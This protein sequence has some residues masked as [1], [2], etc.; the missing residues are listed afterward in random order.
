MKYDVVIVGAGPGG[1]VAALS[2]QKMGLKTALVER[3]KIGSVL[4]RANTCMMVDTEGF[5]GEHLK[6]V[7]EN[8]STKIVFQK[9]GFEIEYPDKLEKI[10]DSISFSPSG[11]KVY[12]HNTKIPLY[13]LFDNQLMLDTL[14]SKAE[15]TGVK[16]FDETLAI[17]AEDAGNYVKITLKTRSGQE[18]IEGKIAIVGEGLK[19][20]IAQKTGANK[21][22]QVMGRGPSLQ[23]TLDNVNFPFPNRAFCTFYGSTYS[24]GGGVL[25]MAPCK[26]G[27][28]KFYVGISGV[29]PAKFCRVFLEEFFEKEMLKDWFKD[30]E[31]VARNG[32]VVHLISP[33]ADPV[34][35]NIIFIGD[36]AGFAETMYQGAM[37]CGF[38]A[39]K[40]A[41]MELEGKNGKD[42]YREF[43]RNS[44]NWNKNP[45][46][47]ADYLKI[48]FFYPFFNN[49]ELD[50][51]F[52]LVDGKTFEGVHDPYQQ[53]NKLFDI[54]L[55][56]KDIDAAIAEK[57]K[58]F[59]K[60]T[61]QDIAQLIIQKRQFAKKE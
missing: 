19:S 37:M 46:A 4:M 52:G 18:Y 45:Q 59:Q 25:Y 8:R 58:K 50:Y 49:E 32:A 53:V 28:K 24:R 21:Q 5:N 16:I 42:D 61:M 7:E 6:I 2:A 36:S 17:G 60:I 9:N 47:M 48:G 57:A 31:I 40:A 15:E 35:G 10:Y 12:V 51:L 3:R 1:S 33:M 22:R 44:F 23:Y 26:G 30:A 41:K 29:N 20:I 27:E 14:T 43:W 39:A 11:K 13:H 55:Q 34:Q 54:L 38:R 56:S